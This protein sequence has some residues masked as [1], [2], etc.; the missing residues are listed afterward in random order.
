MGEIQKTSIPRCLNC[1]NELKPTDLF[2]SHCGQRTRG[3]KVPLRDFVGDFFKDYFTVD[4]KFFMSIF[5]IFIKPGA[6][7]KR[8]NDGKRKA[9]IAPLRMYLFTSF[10]YFFLL[11]LTFKY[12]SDFSDTH[13]L[14]E[15][16]AHVLDSLLA[17]E[18]DTLVISGLSS[19]ID[20][21]A[22]EDEDQMIF[23]EDVEEDPYNLSEHV[24]RANDNPEIF[25]QSALRV[26]S[27]TLFFLVP[28]FALILWLFHYRR[29][30]F[31][32]QHLV[33]ALHLHTFVFALFSIALGL[34]FWLDS[35]LELLITPLIILVY[36]ALSLRIVYSQKIFPSIVKT[37]SIG[38]IYFFLIILALVPTIIA[39][40]VSV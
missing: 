9:F 1:G 28:V 30:R 14:N 27:I 37:I 13:N 16:K 15:Q 20:S 2:C 38:F 7:T 23:L 5:L 40:V 18:R 24:Q 8:F 11:S 6:L 17:L 4:S 26:G 35:D 36:T 22:Y 12:N 34:N 3:A 10:I 31:Y 32:V 39:A 19:D 29:V 21:L 25:I 33:H